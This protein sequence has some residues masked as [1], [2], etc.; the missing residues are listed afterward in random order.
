MRYD[1]RQT[2]AD[3]F[4]ENILTF[5]DTEAPQDLKIVNLFNVL[6]SILFHRL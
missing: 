5:G 2:R 3:T 4:L 1:G 6:Y